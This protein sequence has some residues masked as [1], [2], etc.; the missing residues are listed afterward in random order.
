MTGAQRRA[1]LLGAELEL[2]NRIRDRRAALLAGP[3]YCQWSSPAGLAALL[4][5]T[6]H[7][8]AQRR[9]LRALLA[10]ELEAPDPRGACDPGRT[11]A[12]EAKTK[13][14]DWMRP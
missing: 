12:L 14:N 1:M 5:G 2:V 3:V 9:E 6:A 11:H 7:L 8:D 10:D 4:M 13:G